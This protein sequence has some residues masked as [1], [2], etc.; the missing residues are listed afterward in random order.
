[1]T[2]TSEE[3][4]EVPE[5]NE[6]DHGSLAEQVAKMSMAMY[7]GFQEEGF[8]SEESF[9]LLKI[10]VAP[11]YAMIVQRMM[12]EEMALLKRRDQERKRGAPKLHLPQE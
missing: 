7:R 8:S 10:W 11:N 5:N 1:M 9:D 4:I 12:Q 3:K 6:E 2:A